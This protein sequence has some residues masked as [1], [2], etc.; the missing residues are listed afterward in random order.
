MVRISNTLYERIQDEAKKLQ[1][2][3]DKKIKS[4]RQRI[5]LIKASQSLARK[6]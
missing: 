3:E 4:R 1:A 2:Q 5:T 6:I